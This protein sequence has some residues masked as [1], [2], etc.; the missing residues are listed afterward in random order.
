M[1]Y[2]SAVLFSGGLDSTIVLFRQWQAAKRSMME[3][4]GPNPVL[5]FFVDYDAKATTRE[6]QAAQDIVAFLNRQTVIPMVQLRRKNLD[7]YSAASAAASVPQ[8][9]NAQNEGQQSVKKKNDVL[10]YRNL[11]LVMHAM[12]DCEILQVPELHVGFGFKTATAWDSTYKFIDVMNDFLVTCNSL[13]GDTATNDKEVESTMIRSSQHTQLVSPMYDIPRPEWLKPH[14]RDRDI[15]FQLT[16]S[17]YLNG[18]RVCGVC[19]SCV[20]RAAAFKLARVVDPVT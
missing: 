11:M 3:G 20:T 18:P 12:L 19:D 7:L 13:A 1:E 9:L 5:A 8:I 2:H 15:P 16:W 10:P 14:L 6:W 17:C 4:H